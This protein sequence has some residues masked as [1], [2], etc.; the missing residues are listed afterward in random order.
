[1][2]SNRAATE[3]QQSSNR[4]AG[5]RY[6]QKGEDLIMEAALAAIE[7]H[8]ALPAGQAENFASRF[9][10]GTDK[11]TVAQDKLSASLNALPLTLPEPLIELNVRQFPTSRKRAMTS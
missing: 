2:N 9:K 6:T 10:I 7:K 5:D 3:Q 4:H 11:L 8:K 1:M